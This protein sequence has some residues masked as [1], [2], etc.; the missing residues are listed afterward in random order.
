MKL[1]QEAFADAHD[2][3][4]TYYSAIERG[5]QNLSL[6]NLLRLADALGKSLS[7]LLREVERLD[8]ERA[9]KQPPRPPSKGRPPGAKSRWR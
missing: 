4:R 1:T 3:N 5:T 9:V 6:L 2:I 7:Q 8:L